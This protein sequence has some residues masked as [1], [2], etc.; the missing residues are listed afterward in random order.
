VTPQELHPLLTGY[1]STVQ[2]AWS[3]GTAK[4]GHDASPG[5]PV[6][7]CG[8]TSAWLQHRLNL[9]HGIAT[10]YCVGTVWIN[11][12][13]TPEH[14][15]LEIPDVFRTVVDITGDQFGLPEVVCGTYLELTQLGAHY[16]CTK[17]RTSFPD[18]SV[19]P[20]LRLLEEALC[21]SS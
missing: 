7:Q 11:D 19:L 6:G 2:K 20:R 12:K 8:V 9:D 14:V 4:E 15:W 3:V 17:S 21:A 10:Q 13:W 1:R 18:K 5:S 16:T